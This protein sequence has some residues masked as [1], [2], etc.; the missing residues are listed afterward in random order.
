MRARKSAKAVVM[1]IDCFAGPSRSE[2]TLTSSQSPQLMLLEPELISSPV[3]S[4][5]GSVA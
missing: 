3:L 5:T 2:A 4:V 1:R